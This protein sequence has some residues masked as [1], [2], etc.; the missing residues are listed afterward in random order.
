MA[1]SWQLLAMLNRMQH[2]RHY[3]EPE[4]GTNH[5]I[6]V[7]EFIHA[8]DAIGEFSTLVKGCGVWRKGKGIVVTPGLLRN[9]LISQ[10]CMFDIPSMKTGLIQVVA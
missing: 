1:V 3:C 10:P 4:C 8:S 9:S 5:I 6:S 7:N 2:Q